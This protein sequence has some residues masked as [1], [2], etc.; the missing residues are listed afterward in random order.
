MQNTPTQLLFCGKS[1]F[2]H[3]LPRTPMKVL[4]EATCC[5]DEIF[6]DRFQKNI[7]I[8]TAFDCLI[9]IE[10]QHGPVQDLGHHR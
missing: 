9:Q 1:T 6:G 7:I 10:T 4:Q 8:C 2:N 5:I 3:I